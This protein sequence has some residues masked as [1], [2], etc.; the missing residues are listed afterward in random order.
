MRQA[1]REGCRMDVD[2]K[3]L[4][5]AGGLPAAGGGIPPAMR[6]I[7]SLARMVEHHLRDDGYGLGSCQ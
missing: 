5:A 6:T 7:C 4:S 3:S 1:N 2:T